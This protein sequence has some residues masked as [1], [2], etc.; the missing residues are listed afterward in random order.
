M[1]IF[2]LVVAA[3]EVEVAVGMA[4]YESKAVRRQS[5]AVFAA[6]SVRVQRAVCRA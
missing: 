6:V 4:A 2:S 1:I 5:V 3:L